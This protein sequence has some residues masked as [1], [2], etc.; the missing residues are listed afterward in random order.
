MKPLDSV[1]AL[2]ALP[3]LAALLLTWIAASAFAQDAAV[4]PP[5]RVAHLSVREGGV[6]FAPQGENEWVELPRNRPLTSGDRVWTDKGARAELQLGAATVHVDGHSHLG[7]GELDDRA[8]HFVLQQGAVNARVRELT[9]GENFEIGTPNVALR[10]LQPGDY[11]IDVNAATG[12]THVT[13]VSGMAQV[14][15][16]G[17]DSVHL[18][19]GQQAVFAGRFLAQSRTGSF[20]Q[21]AFGQWAAE[22]NRLE[23]QSIAARHVPRGV[24]GYA[25]LDRHG[26]WAQDP[27]H[28]AVW[29]PQVTVQDWAPYRHGHWSWISPWGWTWIDDA[30]WGFAPFHYGRWTT[31][32]DRWAWVPGRMAARPVYSPAMVVFLGGGNGMQFSI[33]SGPAVG[34]YPLAPG[35]AWYPVYRA[36]PRYL[37]FA[38]FN[39]NLAAHPRHASNHYWRQR[40]AGITAV[41]VDDFR[42]G[43]PVVRHWQSVQPQLVGQAQVG[44]V[45]GRPERHR[46]QEPQAAPRVHAA[47]P[48]VR[49]QWRAQHEQHRLQRDAERQARD[50]MRQQD[51]ARQQQDLQ[52]QRE[53]VIRQQPAIPLAGEPRQQHRWE[54]RREQERAWTLPQPQPQQQQVQPVIQ[55]QQAVPLAREPRGNGRWHRDGEQP[56]N[57]NGRWN[58]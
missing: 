31:I 45:P 36:S 11:R 32:G 18:G 54:G 8:A 26:Q 6:V 47:P 14:F 2:R 20:R 58:R 4:D 43:R 42:R 29:Y 55:Q 40:P 24:V 48:A 37:G 35:E 41:G 7:L 27:Q 13:V 51:F 23:D 9:E 21:D 17:G 56:G 22:R 53:Q 30:P 39:I 25:E 12:E 3:W 46:G 1:R 28:G 38:N 52:R 5:G 15:G 34:W 49:E 33:G 10:A 44:V 16:E 19:A 50:Q 57:G